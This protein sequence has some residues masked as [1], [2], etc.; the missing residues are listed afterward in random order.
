MKIK[1]KRNFKATNRNVRTFFEAGKEYDV[2]QAVYDYAF[3]NNLI[4]DGKKAIEELDNKAIKKAPENKSFGRKKK[5]KPVI[6]KTEK[7]D[8]NA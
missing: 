2:E 8:T 3:Q 7:D 4:D 6:K 1:V 5:V